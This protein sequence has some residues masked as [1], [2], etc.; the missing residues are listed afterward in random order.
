MLRWERTSTP[1]R[2][3][4]APLWKNRMQ[5]EARR[6]APGT[7]AFVRNHAVRAVMTPHRMIP[8]EPSPGASQKIKSPAKVG[9][10][11]HRS[12]LEFVRQFRQVGF[13]SFLIAVQAFGEA[14]G[15]VLWP[16]Y[17]RRKLRW[18][19]H[20]LAFLQTAAQISV[21]LGTLLYPSII[22]QFGRRATLVV[23][24][25]AGVSCTLAFAQ[26]SYSTIL[27]SSSVLDST[28]LARRSSHGNRG[29]GETTSSFFPP[30]PVP[31]SGTGGGGKKEV[32]EG[33]SAS[34]DGGD[35][36][37]DTIWILQAVHVGNV[38]VF[39]AACAMIKA[40]VQHLASLSV[41]AHT[42][43]RVFSFLITM[44]SVGSIVGNLFGTRFSAS[45]EAER[46]PSGSAGPSSSTRGWTVY[47]FGEDDFPFLV[48][49][50]L[51]VVAGVV[52]TK[53]VDR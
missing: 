20:E 17:V 25:V 13:F 21:I 34:F 19:S 48:A 35:P 15:R 8:D 10:H 1:I 32:V 23:P 4:V 30:P 37:N 51:F 36:T 43:A 14:V 18:D 22:A 26:S 28:V 49:S 31:D 46:G 5:G 40:M 24:L 52:V 11:Q 16:L 41:P 2:R 7:T 29:T 9:F 12:I 47:D 53:T 33:S 6:G 39:L 42:Q 44:S 38:L 45:L 3:W 27:V 50:L